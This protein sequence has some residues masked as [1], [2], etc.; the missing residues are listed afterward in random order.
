MPWTEEQQRAIEARNCDLLVA[1]AAGSGKTAVLVE[2]IYKLVCE[3]AD[4]ER[5]LIVTFT[6]AVAAEMRE[7]LATRFEEL[8]DDERMRA[9][10]QACRQ[11]HIQTLHAFCRDLCRAYFQAADVDPGFRIADQQE[12]ELMAEY[13]LD[14]ALLE[15][16]EHVDEPLRQLNALR[17]PDTLRGM[18]LSLY[19]FL[20]SRTDADEWLGSQT[21]DAMRKRQC[22]QL[23]Q[24]IKAQ[25]SHARN[26]LKGALEIAESDVD[27]QAYAKA[28]TQDIECWP[29]GDS[30]DALAAF[31]PSRFNAEKGHSKET[32]SAPASHLI[33]QL[34]NQAKTLTSN[35]QKLA[36][37]LGANAEAERE[38]LNQAIP[39]LARLERT[40]EH[41]YTRRKRERSVLDFDDLEHRALKALSD[42]SVA[43]SVRNMFDYVFVDEY[44]DISLI[45]E[46]ILSQVAR[47]HAMF[48]VGDVKQSIY[49]F[50]Q[51]EPAI[52]LGKYDAFNPEPGSSALRIDLNRNFRS[53][54][55]VV[56]FV[57]GVFGRCMNRVDYDIDYDENAALKP[58]LPVQPDDPAVEIHLLGDAQPD[59]SEEA[60][61][62]DA[63]ETALEELSREE[64][65]AH[66]AASV[67]KS[68]LGTPMLDQKTGQTRSIAARDIV[69]L[70][71]TVRSIAPR[72]LDVLL[73]EGIPA[74]ADAAGGY[75][76]AL[77]VR[78]VLELLRIIDN[79]LRDYD[80]LGVLHSPMFGFNA[81]DLGAIRA[82]TPSGSFADALTAFVAPPSNSGAEPATQ[83]EPNGQHAGNAHSGSTDRQPN[84][85]CA[86]NTPTS[87]DVANEATS[88]SPAL[89]CDTPNGSVQST[90]PDAPIPEQSDLVKRVRTFIEKLDI[91]QND[92]RFMPL[93]ELIWLLLD[94][95]GYYVYVG[96]LPGGLERQANLRLLGERA[97][98]YESTQFGGLHG[99][100]KYVEQLK[101]VGQDM[102][103]AT[104]LGEGDDVVR[105]M[106]VHKSKGLEFPVVIGLNL[107][108]KLRGGT[109]SDLVLNG[110]MGLGLY[111]M[112]E[113]LAARND[114]IAR[115]AVM[116]RQQ[117]DDLAEELRILYVLL[118]R[119]R[120]RL[121]LIGS[122]NNLWTREA[123]WAANALPNPSCMLDWIMPAAYAM[124]MSGEARLI[125]KRHPPRAQANVQGE[126]PL[127]QGLAQLR[128]EPVD[129][130]VL[131]RMSWRYP[132]QAAV[133]APLKLTA[134]RLGRE[135]E[136]PAAQTECRERPLF[137]S[138]ADM[139]ALERGIATHT[140]M[141]WLELA[142]LKGLT[143]RELTAELNRQLDE[144]RA[145][146]TL[147]EAQRRGVRLRAIAGFFES[148]IGVRLLR[149]KRIEREWPFNL[150]MKAS[151]ALL[152]G[153]NES[154]G[155]ERILVQ[156]I[157]DCC[158][159]EDDE[160]V[161]VDYKTDRDDDPELL[162]DRYLSQLALYARA[163]R[164]ITGMNVRQMGLFLLR[165]GEFLEF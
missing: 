163:L 101:R 45:Q 44:Q 148:D 71:R 37:L 122:I 38:Y 132:Y 11:A 131:A 111:R 72:A 103:T 65:E 19:R 17:G 125:I 110:D 93:S 52:F 87:D 3:G 151:E 2:R 48:M 47:P 92:A 135:L 33:K 34:R 60:E 83:A 64:S 67:I 159:V 61:P 108:A 119:A 46:S 23:T 153:E 27:A 165:K 120:D 164:E 112:D 123:I 84:A 49:R 39:T 31:T 161:L 128:A 80:L 158:F 117:R 136:G 82:H 42:E 26:M 88:S 86:D 10:A 40:F 106:S 12:A 95:T 150:R 14:D 30:L 152:P 121:V 155:D 85:P 62:A 137:L 8:S 24:S 53:R 7:R 6:N 77:E 43:Q 58:G 109:P 51:A 94:E 13:A 81:A 66:V 102:S 100:L 129:R 113:E 89:A 4:I 15:E 18:V 79:R 133:M 114:T 21:S 1:A 91:W 55:N 156:G 5:M 28:L 54:A 75:F 118:T 56:N 90:S 32:T 98:T 134:S 25:L 146:G 20:S 147:T 115:Q 138:E 104:T 160:W 157:I 149:S 9:Q 22:D 70:S 139:N 145:R 29:T 78:Q 59:T 36:Q 154:P 74:Y 130:A 73:G 97:A 162:R 116:L 142:P 50:R 68:L 69:V 144:L 41:K 96:A 105:I 143:G 76:D 57:N 126:T 99:F 127:Q 141:Q 16:Y 35:A 124:Q 140:V 63:D 107:G